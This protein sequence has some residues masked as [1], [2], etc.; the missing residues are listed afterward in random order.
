VI[1]QAF[2]ASTLGVGSLLLPGPVVPVTSAQEAVSFAKDIR[3]ILHAACEGCHGDL[4][5]SGL[6]LRTRETALKGGDQG[7][8]IV[9]GSAE[10]SRL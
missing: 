2:V 3:P 4:Q 5:A 7:V 8:A 6:D 1:R 9:P 10:Q